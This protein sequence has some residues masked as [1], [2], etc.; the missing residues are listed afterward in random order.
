MYMEERDLFPDEQKGWKRKAWG[1]KDQL[2]I[3]KTI[4]K[5]CKRR[6]TNISIAWIDYCKAYDLV[7]HSWIIECL[8]MIGVAENFI[9]LLVRS[10]PSWKTILTAGK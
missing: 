5:N 3:D 7:P 1:T 10:M 4:I 8:N 2:L 9:E 6:H